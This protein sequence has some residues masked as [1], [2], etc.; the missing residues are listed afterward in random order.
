[1]FLANLKI[2]SPNEWLR[3]MGLKLVGG[4]SFPPK[5]REIARVEMKIDFESDKNAAFNLELR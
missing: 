4:D 3:T 1:M 2:R 5:Y